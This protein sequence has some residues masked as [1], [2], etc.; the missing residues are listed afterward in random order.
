MT[1]FAILLY[2]DSVAEPVLFWPT[3]GLVKSCRLRLATA[4]FFFVSSLKS[5][6][7]ARDSGAVKSLRLHLATALFFRP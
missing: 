5:F 6:F 4:Q 3:P 2:H 7:E 1:D